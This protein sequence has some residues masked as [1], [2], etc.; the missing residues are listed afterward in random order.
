M[1]P[2]PMARQSTLVR[3]YGKCK[4][5]ALQSCTLHSH[6]EYL[7]I[8]THWLMT[9]ASVQTNLG[10]SIFEQHSAGVFAHRALFL[11][12]SHAFMWGHTISK[13]AVVE[14]EPFDFEKVG[15]HDQGH[16]KIEKDDT[17]MMM[18]AVP[19]ASVPGGYQ[20]PAP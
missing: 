8:Y 4:N 15:D 20:D 16:G 3:R 12:R 2:V 1:R 17:S 11:F 13:I 14:K 5:L 9:I 10:F 6:Q 18:N 7:I 19:P